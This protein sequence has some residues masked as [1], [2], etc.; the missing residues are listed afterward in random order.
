MVDVIRPIPIKTDDSGDAYREV[1]ASSISEYG[2]V[3]VPDSLTL[4]DERK[5]TAAFRRTVLQPGDVVYCIKGSVGKC[6]IVP[7][8]AP[9]NLVL[10]Q[11][12]V[13]MRLKKGVDESVSVALVQYL[14]SGTFKQYLIAEV[15]SLS[16][17]NGV[18]F[19]SVSMVESFPVP[20]WSQEQ[21][22]KESAT[23]RQ[24]EELLSEQQKII[25]TL[26]EMDLVSI[27]SDW[28]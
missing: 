11:T 6:G 16:A 28:E 12:C 19:M 18:P 7:H 4:V 22:L 9:K 17:P 27:P 26:K 1:F 8:D 15:P 13:C 24:K 20:R 23:F 10:G 5:Q 21:L 25:N 14:R 3:T 2:Q